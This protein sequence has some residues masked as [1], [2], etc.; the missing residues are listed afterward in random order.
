MKLFLF[1]GDAGTGKSFLF[2]TIINAAKYILREEDDFLD[3]VRVLSL[4]P[5]NYYS[6][7]QIVNYMGFSGGVAATIIG[8]KTIESA[9]P[10]MSRNRSGVVIQEAGVKAE[11][12]MM[13]EKLQLVCL[14]EVR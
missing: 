13:Y 1:S 7:V 14:D 3:Q 9:L 11:T 2:K 5:S 8:G 12:N 4:A 10:L 6:V